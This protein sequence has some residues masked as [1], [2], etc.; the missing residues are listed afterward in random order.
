MS[1]SQNNHFSTRKIQHLAIFFCS[2]PTMNGIDESP[3]L[4]RNFMASND[5]NRTTFP[6]R[7]CCNFLLTN[8][9][10]V[11]RTTHWRWRGRFSTAIEERCRWDKQT[12]RLNLS[13]TQ[14]FFSVQPALVLSLHT[15]ADAGKWNWIDPVSCHEWL[16]SFGSFRR[17]NR[18]S[19]SR[20]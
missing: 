14:F 4:C 13:S 12:F 7:H 11:N 15:A 6:L 20:K 16:T 5:I 9:V 8:N 19:Y 1:T 17:K 10:I 18:F 3:Y 2:R